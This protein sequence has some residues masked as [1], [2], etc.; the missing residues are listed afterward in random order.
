MH[1]AIGDTSCKYHAITSFLLPVKPLVIMTD[2]KRSRNIA[3][4]KGEIQTAPRAASGKSYHSNSLSFHNESRAH[5][6]RARE[7]GAAELET[8]QTLKHSKKL[9]RKGWF[10][11]ATS[12]SFLSPP[13]IVYK[14]TASSS[15]QH[16]D[17]QRR[18]V[19]SVSKKSYW[20]MSE[21]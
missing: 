7:P 9:H 15:E 21:L 20:I 12:G 4:Q 16:E 18:I 14:G 2:S 13:W 1:C 19:L 10:L 8:K 11:P 6:N 3:M 17:E 5:R